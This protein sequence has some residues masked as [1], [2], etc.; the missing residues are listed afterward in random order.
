MLVFSLEL[1]QR[2]LEGRNYTVY[3]FY[4]SNKAKKVTRIKVE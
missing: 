3:F 2:H 4:T 1:D